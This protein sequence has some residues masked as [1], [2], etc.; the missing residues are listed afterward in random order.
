MDWEQYQEREFSQRHEG[1]T[2]AKSKKGQLFLQLLDNAKDVLDLGCNDGGFTM[3]LQ[4]SGYNAVGFD[5]PRVIA[6]ARRENPQATFIAGSAEKK[7]P[8]KAEMF[9]AII[10]SE[11][12]EHVRKDVQLVSE[13]H[14][15]LKKSGKLI[16]AT[17]N[18]N[19]FIHTILRKLGRKWDEGKNMHVQEYSVRQ[20][21]ELLNQFDKIDIR[22]IPFSY[23][24]SK[25]KVGFIEK[26]IPGTYRH[27]LLAIAIKS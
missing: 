23:I 16:M 2:L 19:Y 5:L 21:R 12:I 24:D 11:I 9:D 3:L 25:S 7:L 26:L 20:F 15:I 14:R 22:G 10:A 8:F 4:K 6:K 27:T 17:P 13:C 1:T 18:P